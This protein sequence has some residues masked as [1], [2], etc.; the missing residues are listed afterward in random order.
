MAEIHIAH[1]VTL[2]KE[3]YAEIKS[4]LPPESRFTNVEEWGFNHFWL[5]DPN[6]DIV[7]FTPDPIEKLKSLQ[8]E[9]IEL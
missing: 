3:A 8:I 1:V 5:Y 2:S 7:I 9:G 4:A 6:G